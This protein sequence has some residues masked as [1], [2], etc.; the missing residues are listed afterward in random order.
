MKDAPNQDRKTAPVSSDARADMALRTLAR[1]IARQA[2][3][4]FLREG[5]QEPRGS[6]DDPQNQQ[7][8]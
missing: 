6:D 8:G 7:A 1:L 3:G 2:A 4:E 5:A